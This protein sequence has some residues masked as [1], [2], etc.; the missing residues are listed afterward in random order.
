MSLGYG[1]DVIAT[2]NY[3]A[4]GDPLNLLYGF[5]PVKY[6]EIKIFNLDNGKDYLVTSGLN[7]GDKIV[8][9]GVQNLKDGQKVQP[10]TPAQKEANYQQHL[11]DQHD[12]NLA[13]A[14][15]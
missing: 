7:S 10:I 13:T 5:V 6:T 3:Y 2:L 1:A 12:G 8:I 14:F 9:E 11:K 15:N 4:I